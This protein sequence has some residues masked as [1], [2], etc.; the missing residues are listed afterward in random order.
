[1][2]DI[3][4]AIVALA[5]NEVDFVIIGGVALSLHS[6]A[7]V[8]YDLDVCFSRSKEN[9]K[10]IVEALRPFDPRLRGLPKEL[11]FIWDEGTLSHG[12]TF[13]LET[14][15]GDFDLLGEVEGIGTFRE[16]MEFAE[17]WSIYGYAVKIL[18]VDG[19][20]RAK[21]KAG[22]EKDQPGLKILYALREAVREEE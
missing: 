20:I 22:R 14:S 21:E 17:T 15:I 1:M 16:V 18:S 10:K 13:T 7:Y 19:L 4:K 3:K 9:I 11:P 2:I 6:A 12:T 5:S 8:T